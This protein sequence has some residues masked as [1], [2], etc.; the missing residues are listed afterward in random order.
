MLMVPRLCPALVGSAGLRVLTCLPVS[1]GA[2]AMYRSQNSY[3]VN[4][5]ARDVNADGASVT[6]YSPGN[7]FF[8]Q[9]PNNI[10]SIKS[11]FTLTRCRVLS[12]QSILQHVFELIASSRKWVSPLRGDRVR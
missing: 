10:P 4:E 3:L 11:R 12:Y 6:A 9:W 2:M 8:W 7:E 1:D 5:E